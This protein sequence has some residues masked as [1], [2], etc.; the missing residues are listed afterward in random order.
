MA[1]GS[2]VI[3][4]GVRLSVVASGVSYSKGSGLDALD[5]EVPYL[6]FIFGFIGIVDMLFIQ[7]GGTAG[8]AQPTMQVKR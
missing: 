7:V 6:R 5:F 3:S 1:A 4:Y 2:T 8:V